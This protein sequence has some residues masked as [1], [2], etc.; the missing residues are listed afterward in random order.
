MR[1]CLIRLYCTIGEIQSRKENTEVER[2][3][4]QLDE[5]KKKMEKIQEENRNFRK[6]LELVKNKFSTPCTFDL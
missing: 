3:S 2:L 4:K 5:M 6:E 1:E